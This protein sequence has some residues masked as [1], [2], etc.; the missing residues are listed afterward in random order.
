YMQDGPALRLTDTV[1]FT[2]RDIRE[3]QLAKAAIAAG[4]HVLL[5]E[6]GMTLS[7]VHT[8][9][10]AGGFGSFIHTQQ[11]QQIGLLPL[12]SE[13]SIRTVGNAAGKGALCILTQSKGWQDVE[14]IRRSMHYHELSSSAAFQNHFIDQM[15]FAGEGL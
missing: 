4:V 11:A 2:A 13:Q 6:A 8:L 12:V 1:V 3:V 5:E 10:L 14:T 9:Y 7:D 15:L